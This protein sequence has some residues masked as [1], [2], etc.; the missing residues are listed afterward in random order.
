[1]EDTTRDNGR[2]MCFS[3]I[4]KSCNK[5]ASPFPIGTTLRRRDVM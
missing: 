2:C 3:F 5:M 1:M 4:M